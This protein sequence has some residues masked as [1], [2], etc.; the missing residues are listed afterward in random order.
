[1]DPVPSIQIDKKCSVLRKKWKIMEEKKERN[2]IISTINS[3][4]TPIDVTEHYS[5]LGA[6]ISE[7]TK[8]ISVLTSTRLFASDSV[9]F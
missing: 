7:Q 4:C 3:D 6:A 1:M 9:S 2:S 8:T 5:S